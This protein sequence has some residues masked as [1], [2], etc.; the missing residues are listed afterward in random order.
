METH[1]QKVGRVMESWWERVKKAYASVRPWW[2]SWVGMHIWGRTWM[3]AGVSVC[4]GWGR[5]GENEGVGPKHCPPKP[6]RL[7]LPW[8]SRGGRSGRKV[9]GVL[10]WPW[11]QGARSAG[12][13]GWRHGGQGTGLSFPSCQF[14]CVLLSPVIPLS[15]SGRFLNP[16][17]S[18][19]FSKIAWVHTPLSS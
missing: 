1:H 13:Q 10:T 2:P 12:R 3:C 6:P 18:S 16:E 4:G 8:V 14:V 17:I 7:P 5:K 11:L 15:S 19:F 9:G